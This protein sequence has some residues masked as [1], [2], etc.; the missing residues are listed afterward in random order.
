MLF[1][2]G[3]IHRNHRNAG[4]FFSWKNGSGGFKKVTVA[5]FFE[6]NIV[7]VVF[8]S[9]NQLPFFNSKNILKI[10][11][12][13]FESAGLDRSPEHRQGFH[14]SR[15]LPKFD[16]RK[17]PVFLS[18]R[19]ITHR[20]NQPSQIKTLKNEFSILAFPILDFAIFETLFF[21]RF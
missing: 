7:P 18:S 10:E 5:Y 16:F 12:F 9:S 19:L 20:T 8:G 14:P 4:G 13:N 1:S 6:K 11:F 17:S 3:G 21:S 2:S 15:Q